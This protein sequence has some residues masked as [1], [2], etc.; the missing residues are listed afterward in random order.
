MQVIYAIRPDASR[1]TELAHLEELLEK[2]YLELPERLRFDPLTTSQ[3]RVPPPHVLT[4][5]MQYWCTALLLHR[6]LCVFLFIFVDELL[7]GVSLLVFAIYPTIHVP[8]RRTL[9]FALRLGEAMIC[10]F[11]RPIK[12][13]RSVSAILHPSITPSNLN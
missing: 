2:W 11:R 9:K 6:P 7:I 1:T 13:P 3:T 4:L 10:V 12:L 5:H 8:V